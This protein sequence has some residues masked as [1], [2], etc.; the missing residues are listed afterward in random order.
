MLNAPDLFWADLAPEADSGGS[1]YL[2]FPTSVSAA[3]SRRNAQRELGQTWADP[4]LMQHCTIGAL[5]A[6]V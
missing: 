3:R 2:T 1:A 4:L 5:A 6:V